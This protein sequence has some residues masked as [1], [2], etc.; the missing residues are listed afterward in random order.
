MATSKCYVTAA[1]Y[2]RYWTARKGFPTGPEHPNWKGGAARDALEARRIV[3]AVIGHELPPGAI[4]HHVDENQ[5]N[6]STDNL[7]A[8][9]SIAEHLQLHRRMRVRAAGGDPW[10]DRLCRDC[11]PRPASEFRTEDF[12]TAYPHYPSRCRP[13]EQAYDRKRYREGRR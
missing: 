2:A 10:R 9:Q 1:D 7:A 4:V 8:L 3:T 13:C 5:A 12:G 6:N 11:G